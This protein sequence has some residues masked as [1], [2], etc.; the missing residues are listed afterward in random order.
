MVRS[1]SSSRTNVSWNLKVQ[2]HIHNNPHVPV[3]SHSIPF[4]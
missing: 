2:Y 3:L 4:P 1:N